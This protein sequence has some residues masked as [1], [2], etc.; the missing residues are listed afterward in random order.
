MRAHKIVAIL[1]LASNPSISHAW[2]G[3]GSGRFVIGVSVREQNR[4]LSCRA[5]VSGLFRCAPASKVIESWSSY[6]AD[7]LLFRA[8]GNAIEIRSLYE[9]QWEKNYGVANNEWY[10]DFAVRD[11]ERF[12]SSD[13]ELINWAERL[14]LGVRGC[15]ISNVFSSDW[16]CVDLGFSVISRTADEVVMESAIDRVRVSLPAHVGAL[17]K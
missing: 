8:M 10:R 16:R 5:F 4:D 12:T 11:I 6:L 9:N 17:E 3:S 2:N 7:H 15:P 1:L 14:L 13:R